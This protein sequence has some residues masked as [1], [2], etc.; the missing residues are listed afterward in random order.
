MSKKGVN[1]RLSVSRRV[2]GHDL[3]IGVTPSPYDPNE[4]LQ[5]VRRG[6]S[7]SPSSTGDEGR[8]GSRPECKAC[9]AMRLRR[10]RRIPSAKSASAGVATDEPG[11][12]RAWAQNRDQSEQNSARSICG[13]NSASR[14]RSTTRF[15]SHRMVCAHSVNASRL[16][17]SRCTSIT[18]M[19]RA[20]S[21]VSCACAA[22]TR[23]V[24]SATI[25]TCSSVLPVT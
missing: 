1:D 25:P 10:Y 16:R 19:G 14:S 9:T 3:D 22:T 17:G 11:P 5:E 23:L 8:D 15:S 4:A 2:K 7:H 18:T 13:T 6:A 20:R 12:V 24:C 21:A